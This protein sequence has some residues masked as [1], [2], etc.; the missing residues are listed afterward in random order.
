MSLSED[1][2]CTIMREINKRFNK[3]IIDKI[4]KGGCSNLAENFWS[5]ATKFSQGK[6]LSQDH[7]DHYEVSNETAFIRIGAGNVQ[8]THD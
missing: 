4:S 1:G 2:I 8:K 7:S 5:V 6:R 3:S